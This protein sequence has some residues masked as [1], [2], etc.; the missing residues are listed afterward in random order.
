LYRGTNASFE[1]A[2]K[3]FATSVM[4]N[5][6]VQQAATQVVTES[7]RAAASQNFGQPKY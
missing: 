4:S 3:E 5:K 1:K 7:A 2:Q 6:N